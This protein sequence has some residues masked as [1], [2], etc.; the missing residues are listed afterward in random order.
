[1]FGSEVQKWHLNA[2]VNIGCVA[3]L[4]KFC[5]F[6]FHSVFMKSRVS[7]QLIPL[8]MGGRDHPSVYTS[9]TDKKPSTAVFHPTV[10]Q[11]RAYM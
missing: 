4:R 7:A 2:R 10:L 11:S 3:S 9:S 1:M 8:D 6:F 5:K